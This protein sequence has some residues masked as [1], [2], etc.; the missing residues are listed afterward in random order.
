MTIIYVS[1]FDLRGSG[2]MNIAVK[3]C[4]GLVQ[5]HGKDII[6]LGFGYK[7]QEHDHPFRI[8]PAI[9]SH[10]PHM[11][12]LLR[13]QGVDV[14]AVVVALDIPLQA[15]LM[16]DM[17]VPNDVPYIGLFP[18]EGPPLCVSWAMELSRMDAR[19][20]MSR[21]GK[22]AVEEAGLDA[23]YIPIG[24]DPGSWRPPAADERTQIRE[25]LGIP[26]DA[27][28]VLTVADNQ[29]R[30]NLSAAAEA[31]A[32]FSLDVKKTDKH[33]HIKEA[34]PR[35]PTQWHLVTRP[36]SPIGYKL[37]DLAMDM[38]ISDR[39]MLYGRGMP[40]IALW[41]LFAA[42]DAFLLTSKAEGLALPVLEAMACRLPVVATDCCAIHEHLTGGRGLLVKPIHEMTDPWG[43]SRRYLIDIKAAAR[44]LTRLREMDPVKRESMLDKATAYVGKRA[45]DKAVDVLAQAIR[46][47][48]HDRSKP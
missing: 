7:G 34:D 28:V 16:K 44:A 43:N 22:K 26:E 40:F 18:I 20:V 13:Q 4:N 48:Q 30:K 2:Y 24:I 14:E 37:S 25:G 9:P 45:W 21:F 46:S 6:A 47:A 11:V 12:R 41:S 38:G 15:A 35:W 42:S 23:V 3:L 36:E 29:E 27:F 1:D 8:V 31:F 32:R 5:T 39:L 17:Q 19:L 33:G 10:V